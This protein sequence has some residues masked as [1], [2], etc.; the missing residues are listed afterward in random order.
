MIIYLENSKIKFRG[1]KNTMKCGLIGCGRIAHKHIAAMKLNKID[2]VAVCDLDTKRMSDIIAD[3]GEDAQI[4]RYVDYEKMLKEETTLDFVSIATDSGSHFEIAQYCM[5]RG[6][7]IILEKPIT[8]SIEEAN[9]LI[10]LEKGNSRVMVCFQN[11]YNYAVQVTK[12][13]IKEGRLG[14]IS[15]I[16]LNVRWHRDEQYYKKDTWRGTWRADGGAL[17]NQSIHGI[18]I[19]LW[20][21]DS[22]PVSVCGMITNQFHNYIEVEDLGCA[23]IKFENGVIGTIEGTTN[24]YKENYEE[25]LYIFGEKGTIK[26][27]GNVV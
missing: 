9:R 25:T 17:M 8:L 10:Q 23:I 15:H 21:I 5:M 22:N 11:R 14:K 13:A 26:I 4:R 6:I 20:L 1:M 27:G 18:D 19:L 24:T 7:S 16:A 12:R 3:Y 2:L